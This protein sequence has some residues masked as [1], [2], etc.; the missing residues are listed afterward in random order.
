MQVRTL[1]TKPA[2]TVSEQMPI[3]QVREAMEIFRVKC[4]P[5]LREGELVGMVAEAQVVA[6]LRSA[7]TA[8]QVMV[9]EVVTVP[10]DTSAR[11]ALRLAW[12]LH[13]AASPAAGFLA[14]VEHGEILGIVATG[15]L[16]AALAGLSD[17]GGA[18]VGHVLAATGLA[19]EDVSA[20]EEAV[21]FAREHR[22]KLTLLHVLPAMPAAIGE[23]ALPDDLL[24]RVQA[25][26][27]RV[28][29]DRLMVAGPREPRVGWLVVE[30]EPGIEIVRTA[31][32]LSVDL[33][34]LGGQ[35]SAGGAV[36]PDSGTAGY[37]IER[38]PCRVQVVGAGDRVP[39]GEGNF[40]FSSS[41]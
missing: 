8:G 12:R 19:S 15:D 32:R 11:E 7:V 10:P 9:R 14:V 27:R 20:V 3:H 37:V 33:I 5:V 23:A 17:T 1:M 21:R 24:A 35:R 13:R 29:L 16:V 2:V 26:R 30:G 40:T 39:S 36:C 28:T 6:A 22:A 38:A 34:I 31:A 41:G 18:G 4:L 25:V